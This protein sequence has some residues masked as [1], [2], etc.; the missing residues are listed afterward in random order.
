M[1]ERGSRETAER[2]TPRRVSRMALFFSHPLWFPAIAIAGTI[3][4]IHYGVEARMTGSKLWACVLLSIVV[5]LPAV[6][7]TKRLIRKDIRAYAEFS[8]LL[9]RRRKE[10]NFRGRHRFCL[11]V[12]VPMFL[13]VALIGA[14]T[15]YLRIPFMPALG[16]LT[17]LFLLNY[18]EQ[19]EVYEIAVNELSQMEEPNEQ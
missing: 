18:P 10:L 7:L 2:Q 12:P 13:S 14:V 11:L 17:I 6:L 16:L 3:I 8:V 19:V 4:A 1:E 5:G 9:G 15:W